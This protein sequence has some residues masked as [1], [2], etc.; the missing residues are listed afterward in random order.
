MESNVSTEAVEER[1][2]YRS[3]DGKIKSRDRVV[4]AEEY[5]MVCFFATESHRNQSEKY[6]PHRS[7]ISRVL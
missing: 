2:I 3:Q 1:E 5:R 7:N 4:K 6:D